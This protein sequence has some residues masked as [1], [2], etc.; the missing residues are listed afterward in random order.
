[1]G[2]VAAAQIHGHSR[3]CIMQCPGQHTQG[4]RPHAAGYQYRL[5]AL[6]GERRADGAHH[7]QGLARPHGGQQIG[8][9]AHHPIEQCQCAADAVGFADADGPPQQRCGAAAH[10]ASQLFLGDRAA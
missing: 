1:M 6:H 8:A 5:L 10:P 3:S 2:R 7:V 9:C 4:R